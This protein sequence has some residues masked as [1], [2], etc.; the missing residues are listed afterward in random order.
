M[1]CYKSDKSMITAACYKSVELILTSLI[2][3]K[4][5]FS[6]SRVRSRAR[7]HDHKSHDNIATVAF[8]PKVS[9]DKQ[10]IVK[11]YLQLDKKNS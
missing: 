2:I 1:F 4:I 11:I 3:M 7:S 10:V 5:K 8:L 6:R 9:F